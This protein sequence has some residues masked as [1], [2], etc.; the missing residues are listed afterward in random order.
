MKSHREPPEKRRAISSG[1]LPHALHS[2]GSLTSGPVL[3]NHGQRECLCL[4]LLQHLLSK[5]GGSR[6]PALPESEFPSGRH[7]LP[8]PGQR[9]GFYRRRIRP[10]R[11]QWSFHR[12]RLLPRQAEGS[13]SEPVPRRYGIRLHGPKPRSRQHLPSC[14]ATRP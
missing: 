3:Q 10:H 4:R 14:S 7:R 6:S 8:K 1:C 13:S 5:S 2:A 9:P 12:K 11:K